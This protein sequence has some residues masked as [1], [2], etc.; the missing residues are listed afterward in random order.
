MY[1][2]KTPVT[3]VFTK[4]I[5]SLGL[6]I[7]VVD[8][9]F[10]QGVQIDDSF[11]ENGFFILPF[12]EPAVSCTGALIQNDDK[13][14]ISAFNSS[15][16][17]LLFIRLTENGTM[18]STYG[19]NGIATISGNIDFRFEHMNAVAQNEDGSII[20][21][22][23]CT[24]VGNYYPVDPT[25][26]KLNKF[27]QIDSTFGENGFAKQ[28]VSELNYNATLNDVFIQSDNS[29]LFCGY[30]NDF[31][32]YD[33]NHFFIGRCLPNGSPDPSFGNNGIVTEDFEGSSCEA[34][35]IFQQHDS[36]ILLGGKLN[37]DFAVVRYNHFGKLDT[38]FANGGKFS[39]NVG[40]AVQ[41]NAIAELNDNTIILAGYGLYIDNQDCYPYY[42]NLLVG[43]T[44]DGVL[45]G[46]FSTLGYN[47][48]LAGSCV[49]KANNLFIQSDNKI[50]VGGSGGDA[51][52]NGLY[53]L[54]LSRLD[55]HGILD[56][57]I[58]DDGYENFHSGLDRNYCVSLNQQ[59]DGKLIMAGD[60]Y[61]S[62]HDY[63]IAMRVDAGLIP[64]G[65]TLVEYEKA[66]I[67]SYNK[68]IYLTNKAT[69]DVKCNLVNALGQII[70]T[71]TTPPGETTYNLPELPDGWYVLTLNMPYGLV[72][73]KLLFT[74]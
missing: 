61:E 19:E 40:N 39:T 24:S 31:G 20:A 18:D 55:E 8:N 23:S 28:F 44:Q 60:A 2:K 21:G 51:T 46:D 47:Q 16:Q 48:Y 11:G 66:E 71:F 6:F 9:S 13:I 25:L 37:E 56:E 32:N 72:T 36:K 35:V 26:I 57:S 67:W 17:L 43:L 63:L 14:I 70:L 54:T 59:S 50:L 29:I 42:R 49:S 30:Y 45:S 64:P 38:T 65:H 27:G 53:K 62:G 74:N 10:S 58:G 68:T 33:I 12:Q 69:E 41:V 52:G 1:F 7:G 22:L 15:D 73:H 3:K 4:A 5:V 34:E